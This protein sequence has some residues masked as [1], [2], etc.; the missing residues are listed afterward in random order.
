MFSV[1]T[2]IAVSEVHRLKAPL[3]INV[4]DFGIVTEVKPIQPSKAPLPI[5]V[6]DA[7]IVSSVKLSQDKKLP[8]QSQ[9]LF[10]E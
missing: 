3:P 4:T 10:Q 9:L 5:E 8:A 6:T 7:G 2:S 1:A